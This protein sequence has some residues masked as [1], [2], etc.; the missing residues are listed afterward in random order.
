MKKAFLFYGLMVF[1]P[2]LVNGSV[3]PLNANSFFTSPNL[4]N[5]PGLG[6]E[7]IQVDVSGKL[8]LCSHS[9]KG[10]IIL[11]VSGGVA[12]YTY[13][14]NT[15]ETTKDRTNLYAGTYTVD[16][17]D[18]EGTVHTERIVVQP[19]FPLILDP[20]EVENASC[21]SGANGK[22]KVSVKIG[23]GEPYTIKWSNGIT[24][25]WEVDQLQPGTYSVTVGDKYNCDVTVSF[26]VKSE[27]EGITVSEDIQNETCTETGNGSINLSVSGGQAPYT[28]SWSNGSTQPNL[29]NLKA[30]SYTV[31]VK[32]QTG[33]S[34]TASYEVTSPVSFSLSENVENPS[35]LGNADGKIDVAVVGGSAPFTY[36]WNNGQGG[37]S[38]YGLEAG[39]YSVLVSDASGCTVSKEFNLT[40]NSQLNLKLVEKQDVSCEGDDSGKIFLEVSGASGEV[41]VLWSDGVKG[42]LT[43][44]NLAPGA[45]SVTATE[46]GGCEVSNSFE[47]KAAGSMNAR[48]ESMLDVDCDQGSITGVAWVSIQGG[49]EPYSIEWN[50][51]DT[52]LREVQF[53]Q[54]KTLQVKISDATGCSVVSEAK[55]D[56]PS[57]STQEGRLNFQFRKLEITNEPEVKVDEQVL[58]ESEIP[59]EFIAWEWH[60]GDGQKS[61]D[62]DPVHVFEKAGAFEVTLTAYDL[63]GCS[64]VEKNTVQVTQPEE[65]VVI[66][67]A[68]SPNGDGLNDT[69]IPKMKAVTN[70][71]MEV[72]NTWGEKMYATTSLESKGWDGTYKGQALPAGNY[73]YKITYTSATGENLSL[74]GG[75]TLIR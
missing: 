52:D 5:T 3:L 20:I 15:L 28:Y 9:E 46:I 18:A 14:W 65:M 13:K 30:G 44:E 19:P 59:E 60:F 10:H 71:S 36:Q 42:L 67:N 61:T 47:I 8:A 51:G 7:V 4:E 11:T 26:E 27:S 62:K 56:Y 50:T 35:C 63:Y 48:I 24:D 16:I 34:Y 73:L 40:N 21:G 33:C 74:T 41:E 25:Q 49:V 69:F 31:I 72:F 54:S 70:F 58:F 22:A 66:P 32:D 37:P 55:V 57:F 39:V 43:R 38:L 29:S 53:F 75:I 45:Y 6:S 68:F 23:R 12:P 2:L 64:S 17:T 1:L